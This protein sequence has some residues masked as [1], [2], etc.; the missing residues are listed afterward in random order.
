MEPEAADLPRRRRY[1][2]FVSGK[3]FPLGTVCLVTVQCIFFVVNCGKLTNAQCL[4]PENM[5][6]QRYFSSWNWWTLGCRGQ[7]KRLDVFRYASSPMSH[8]G[9]AHLFSNCFVTLIFG[10]D[11]ELYQG[12]LDMLCAWFFGHVFGL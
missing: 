1:A 6:F 11:M 8:Y 7:G 3:I 10:I 2:A 9:F 5:S 12:P 4:W